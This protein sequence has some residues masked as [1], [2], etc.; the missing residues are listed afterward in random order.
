MART[1]NVRK[2]SADAVANA[3]SRV[4][5]KPVKSAKAWTELRGNRPDGPFRPGKTQ[6]ERRR[7]SS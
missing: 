2:D 7:R 1:R 5:G 6:H 3:G 4:P